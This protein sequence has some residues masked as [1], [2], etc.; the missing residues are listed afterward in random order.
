MIKFLVPLSLLVAIA[1]SQECV[2]YGFPGVCTAIP[3]IYTEDREPHCSLQGALVQGCDTPDDSLAC[4]R[5]VV[6]V[7]TNVVDPLSTDIIGAVR[8]ASS[9]PA[10]SAADARFDD[11]SVVVLNLVPAMLPTSDEVTKGFD[12]VIEGARAFADPF[13]IPMLRTPAHAVGIAAAGRLVCDSE[14]NSAFWPVSA[15]PLE[16]MSELKVDLVGYAGKEGARASD[17]C[18]MDQFVHYNAAGMQVN[19]H[20]S[21]S[22]IQTTN[23]HGKKVGLLSF[24]PFDGVANSMKDLDAARNIVAAAAPQVDVLVVYFSA[25][26]EGIKS[27]GS[28]TPTAEEMAADGTTSLGSPRLFAHAVVDAG[29]DVVF[30]SGS[31]I[32]GSEVYRGKVI[33]Y[34]LGVSGGLAY[35]TQYDT[36]HSAVARVVVGTTGNFIGAHLFVLNGM[37]GASLATS[38]DV[39]PFMELEA[40]SKQ[41]F[42]FTAPRF[43]PRNKMCSVRHVR[44]D[45]FVATRGGDDL[46][47]EGGA[48]TRTTTT[49]IIPVT[50]GDEDSVANREARSISSIFGDKNLKWT[51]VKDRIFGYQRASGVSVGVRQEAWFLGGEVCNDRARLVCEGQKKVDVFNFL[52]KTWTETYHSAPVSLGA[53]VT[54]AII[55]PKL[56]VLS[57]RPVV[58][59]AGG[60]EVATADLVS[61]ITA[62]ELSGISRS[63]DL[64]TPRANAAISSIGDLVIVAGG[65][66]PSGTTVSIETFQ[67]VPMDIGGTSNGADLIVPVTCSSLTSLGKAREHAAVLT[68][69]VGGEVYTVILGGT[70]DA[71]R[72]VDMVDVIQGSV[73][74][75]PCSTTSSPKLTSFPISSLPGAS[76][77]TTVAAGW[78]SARFDYTAHNGA[79]VG[80]IMKNGAATRDVIYFDM[81][82]CN[83]VMSKD[84]FRVQTN[85][86]SVPR[87]HTTVSHLAGYVVAWGGK[88]LQFDDVD[89]LSL[90]S[91]A[92]SSVPE[93]VAPVRVQQVAERPLPE[94]LSCALGTSADGFTAVFVGCMNRESIPIKTAYI[95]E[96]GFVGADA[97]DSFRLNGAAPSLSPAGFAAM[98]AL[99]AL[100]LA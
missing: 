40:V 5:N 100:L 2:S 68:T 89:V 18:L 61:T 3:S 98:A 41:E 17:S 16:F 13:N 70:D 57:Q 53:S 77:E 47:V 91:P 15:W 23:V 71:F 21:P 26:D 25:M 74:A 97:T 75:D 42:P 6:D 22:L 99:A 33:F 12:Q 94:L 60:Q 58:V 69:T 52:S 36:K 92:D 88:G 50:S 72:P 24:S 37:P 81:Q 55:E 14:A 56:S 8:D 35:S 79:F 65:R 27:H 51:L 96:A 73:S 29:A 59:I 85:A 32:R 43:M 76:A 95:V 64:A 19:D 4:C 49:P 84:C 11:A 80:G 93:V 63:V 28:F 62:H 86:L 67:V 82:F 90:A 78:Q 83:N 7:V 48:N 66:T 34:S 39:G 44:C 20:K 87:K 9:G 10:A 45:R 31:P 46:V 38:T 54:G 1:S 30:S